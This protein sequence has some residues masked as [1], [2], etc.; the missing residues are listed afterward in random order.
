M[1]NGNRLV[2]TSPLI[3]KHDILA[4]QFHHLTA[5]Q[6]AIVL[7]VNFFCAS[8]LGIRLIWTSFYRAPKKGEKPSVH[9]FN[10][11]SDAG[12]RILCLHGTISLRRVTKEEAD[13]ICK[14]INTV[15]PYGKKNVKT[16]I[17]HRVRGGAF[18]FHLQSRI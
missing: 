16:C 15:F 9:H 5:R 2:Y 8:N 18:H 1:A 17:F 6:K 12:S 4:G 10:R 3:C 7:Y 11:G 13:I 14:E